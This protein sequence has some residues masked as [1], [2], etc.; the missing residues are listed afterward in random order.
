MYLCDRT[1]CRSS[2]GWMCEV[3]PVSPGTDT[4]GWDSSYLPLMT[5]HT[6][7]PISTPPITRDLSGRSPSLPMDSV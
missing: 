3:C 1:S 7:D 5:C 4:R 6:H 2:A